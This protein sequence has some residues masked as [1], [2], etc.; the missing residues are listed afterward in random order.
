MAQSTVQQPALSPAA[1]HLLASPR[2]LPPLSRWVAG[3]CANWRST[4]HRE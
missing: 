4:I 2:L 1:D 3:S